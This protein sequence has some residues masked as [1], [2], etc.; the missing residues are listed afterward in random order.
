MGEEVEG[1]SNGKGGV[2]GGT[3]RRRVSSNVTLRPVFCVGVPL[4]RILA[5]RR[6]YFP[7]LLE[8]G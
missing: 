7:P 6:A 5:A 2:A 4:K 8:V 1:N 3:N